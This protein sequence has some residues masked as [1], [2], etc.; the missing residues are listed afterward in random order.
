M[1]A[2]I[3]AT[4]RYIISLSG[5]GKC[6][7][8]S[9]LNWIISHHMSPVNDYRN[10]LMMPDF[11]G[12]TRGN[13]KAVAWRASS[14]D[15]CIVKPGFIKIFDILIDDTIRTCD[16]IGSKFFVLTMYR[17]IGTCRNLAIGRNYQGNNRYVRC[18]VM[19]G[20]LGTPIVTSFIWC[21]AIGWGF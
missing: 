2:I 16:P 14:D 6:T 15:R 1:V 4:A 11:W 12:V 10:G 8:L 21:G 5:R 17:I 7:T 13:F 20:I 19:F 18:D 9:S 3:H